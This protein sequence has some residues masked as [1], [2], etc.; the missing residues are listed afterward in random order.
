MVIYGSKEFHDFIMICVVK[1]H[2]QSWTN[3]QIE[4]DMEIVIGAVKKLR[5][6]RPQN[7]KSQRYLRTLPVIPFC[8]FPH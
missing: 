5:S 6:L 8:F 7:D 4:S 3:E 1:C 2:L